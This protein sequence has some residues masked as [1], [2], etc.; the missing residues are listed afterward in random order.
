MEDDEEKA[1]YYRGEDSVDEE[2]VDVDVMENYGRVVVV[3]VRL[4]RG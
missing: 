2:E 4:L 1:N 3:T